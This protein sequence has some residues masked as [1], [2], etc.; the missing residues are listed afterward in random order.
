MPRTRIK[1]CGITSEKD[2]FA[3]VEAGAD[4]IGFVFEKSSKRYVE[5]ENA[6]DYACAVPP[7]VMKV[8]LLVNPT[9]DS[10]DAARELFPFDLGQLHGDEPEKTVSECGP[11]LIKAIRFDEST[12][13]S[14]IAR[15]NIVHQIDAL[16]IDGSTGGQGEAFDWAKLAPHVAKCDHPII[17]AGGLTPE[18]VGEA[19]RTLRPYAVDVS[20]GIEDSPGVKSAAKMAAFVEAVREADESVTR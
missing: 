8:G 9:L 1:F 7:F 20:T 12:I 2:A 14:E 15:W 18:N 11:D 3:A 4:A 16:L 19:I 6:W 5:P 10:Y 13:E 17:L